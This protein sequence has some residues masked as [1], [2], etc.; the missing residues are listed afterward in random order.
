MLYNI[1]YIYIHKGFV[2]VL[3]TFCAYLCNIEGQKKKLTCVHKP[4]QYWNKSWQFL[5][6]C[7]KSWQIWLH[8]CVTFWTTYNNEIENVCH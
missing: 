5:K 7:D 3:P 2:N 8:V 6:H 4:W 1:I